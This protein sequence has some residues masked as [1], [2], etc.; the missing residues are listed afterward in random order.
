MVQVCET[1]RLV[2]RRLSLDDV[3]ALT[4]ILSDPEVMKHSVNGVCDEAATESV[5][6]VAIPEFKQ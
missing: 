5:N 2:L 6:I 1:E 4:E 3:P